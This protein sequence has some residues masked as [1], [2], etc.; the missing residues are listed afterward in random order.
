LWL[1]CAVTALAVACGGGSTPQSPTAPTLTTSEAVTPSTTESPIGSPA[2]AIGTSVS[3]VSLRQVT[4]PSGPLAVYE[5]TGRVTFEDRGAGGLR[6]VSIEIDLLDSEGGLNRVPAPIN[7]TL[8]RGGTATHL[9]PDRMSLPAG[10][11]PR[12]LRVTATGID[13]DGRSRTTDTGEGPIVVMAAPT[14]AIVPQAGDV[15]V[16][17]AGDIASCDLPG[18]AATARL[19]DGI[20]GEVLALGD[21]VY[22]YGTTEAYATCYQSTWGRHR[23]RTRPTPGNHD[24][25]V[26]FGAPYFSYFGSA[27]GS[28]AGYYSF[29]LGGW[30]VLSLNSNSGTGPSSAQ[31]AWIRADLAAHPSLCTLAFWHHPRFSSGPSGNTDSMQNIWFVL[32]SAGV[33]VVVAAH[34]HMYERFAPLDYEGRP[35]PTGIRSFV[36]GTGGAY[37]YGPQVIQPYSESRGSDWGVLKL[38]LRASGYSWAFVPIAGQSFRDEGSD[39]CK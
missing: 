16:V 37:R 10:R 39:S 28:G 17:A 14:V 6:F 5:V 4:G 21:N 15:T 12:V 20:A 30:H 1:G 11:T 24:W 35:S 3:S 25:G 31:L 7:L 36:A 23:G 34:D 38:T 8:A 27:A 18:A 32:D 33:D 19:I 2:G 29:N 26:D 13:E 22:P 9:L